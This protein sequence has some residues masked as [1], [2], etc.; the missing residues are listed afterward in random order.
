MK[1]NSY[2]EGIFT[3][4]SPHGT[5]VQNIKLVVIYKRIDRD[6]IL[7]GSNQRLEQISF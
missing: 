6:M 7:I 2:R 5:F 3:I 4:S 1:G